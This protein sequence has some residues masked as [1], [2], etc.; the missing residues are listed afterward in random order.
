M[1]NIQTI[2]WIDLLIFYVGPSLRFLAVERQLSDLTIDSS[3]YD[4]LLCSETLVSDMRRVWELLTQLE[5]SLVAQEQDAP[6][7]RDGGK[8]T[9]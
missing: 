6:G 2:N 9:S 8:R 3:Q 7:P 4:I 1:S 5:Y